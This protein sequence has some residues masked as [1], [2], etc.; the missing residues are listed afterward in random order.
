M[1]QITM[2][3]TRKVRSYAV[4]IGC[5]EDCPKCQS[6]MERRKRIKGPTKDTYF[7]LEWDYCPGCKHVQHYE[8]YK[9]YEWID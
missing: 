6:Q 5:G 7:Y 2:R 4:I 1:F 8:K 3:R 9:R